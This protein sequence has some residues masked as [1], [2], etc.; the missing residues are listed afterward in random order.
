MNLN[1]QDLWNN[2]IRSKM[3]LIY[4]QKGVQREIKKEILE[5][6]LIENIPKCL[7]NN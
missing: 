7:I 1:K 3:Y 5:Y 6:I 4:F 2:I